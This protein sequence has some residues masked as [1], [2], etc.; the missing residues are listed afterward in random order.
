MNRIAYFSLGLILFSGICSAREDESITESLFALDDSILSHMYGQAG[1]FSNGISDVYRM[2]ADALLSEA[3]QT[4]LNS[5][6]TA[7]EKIFSV[8]A[9][10]EI[11]LQIKRE[12]VAIGIIECTL[13]VQGLSQ[14][15]SGLMKELKLY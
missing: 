3:P 15:G 14:M 9:Q 4:R 6:W 12:A 8:N 11:L 1:I 7:L 5:S 2:N 13:S 10:G